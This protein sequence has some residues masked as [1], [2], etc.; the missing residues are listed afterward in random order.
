MKKIA[1][2]IVVTALYATIAIAG[3]T[4]KFAIGDWEPYTSSTNEKGKM[5]EKVVTEVFKL[6]GIDTKYDYYPWKRSMLLVEKGESDGSFPWIKTPEREK[7]CVFAKSILF[8]DEA[9]YFHLQSKPFEWKS[10]EDIKKYKVGVTLGYS[11]EK[12]YQDNG[13][14]AESVPSEVLNFK[15][16]LGGKIDVYK[17]SK[18]VGY[19]I[20]NSNFTP[21]DAKKFTN[22]PTAVTVDDYYILFSKKNPNAQALADKFDA[23]LKKL[24]DSG[25]Y[26][27]IIA[28]FSG[29]K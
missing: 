28:E 8:K 12:Y 26:D 24:K 1:L 11:D 20:I 22:H 25:A 19:A 21:E 7:D 16:M 18:N 3:E 9:V 17:T 27:K 6:E 14:A 10:L 4:V 15:K 23:G 5:I 13:I 29:A 2:A